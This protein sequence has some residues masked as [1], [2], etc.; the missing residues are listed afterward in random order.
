MREGDADVI[1][2]WPGVTKLSQSVWL[3][4]EAGYPKLT[5]GH[6]CEAQTSQPRTTERS[7]K[8]VV[9]TLDK[10]FSRPGGTKQIFFHEV[11]TH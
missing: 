5:C 1:V 6:V 2:M 8:P 7:S 9:S 3:R 4:D 10:F 11:P